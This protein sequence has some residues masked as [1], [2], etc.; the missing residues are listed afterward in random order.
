MRGLVEG[1]VLDSHISSLL[2]L[3]NPLFLLPARRSTSVSLQP[4]CPVLPIPIPSYPFLSASVLHIPYLPFVL[5]FSV[6]F[7]PCFLKKPPEFHR[8][9]NLYICYVLPLSCKFKH[10]YSNRAFVGVSIVTFTFS[11]L[12]YSFFMVC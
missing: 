10:E 8:T 6:P 4:S 11:P 2:C 5:T 9:C 12:C 7:L 1:A 3:L